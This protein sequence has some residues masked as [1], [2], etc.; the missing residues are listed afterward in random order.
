MSDVH[1][2][3]SFDSATE[4]LTLHRLKP[5][6][7]RSWAAILQAFDFG[8][9]G[10][11]FHM[12]PEIARA[13]LQP[14]CFNL[15]ESARGID[16]IGTLANLQLINFVDPVLGK[17]MPA[18]CFFRRTQSD[19]I[20]CIEL[21]YESLSNGLG[22]GPHGILSAM[23]VVGTEMKGSVTKAL[24]PTQQGG[25]RES[26]PEEKIT[27]ASMIDT[28]DFAWPFLENH[29]DTQNFFRILNASPAPSLAPA[30]EF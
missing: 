20:A 9:L 5:H 14:S 19:E 18:K 21:G 23:I 24:Y 26:S 16:Q 8:T 25:T 22:G 30:P 15:V 17:T 3:L 1:H 10:H 4:K 28:R 27:I 13:S 29:P 12:L 7:H 11:P 6:D 2:Y